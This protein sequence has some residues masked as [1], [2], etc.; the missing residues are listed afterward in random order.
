MHSKGFPPINPHKLESIVDMCKFY[1]E[2]IVSQVCSNQ[3]LHP[4]LNL[5]VLVTTITLLHRVAH[6]K[7]VF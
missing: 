6:K 5:H 4:A 2:Y 3:L 7:N 1:T